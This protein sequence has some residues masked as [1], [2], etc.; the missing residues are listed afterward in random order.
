VGVTQLGVLDKLV[1]SES[2]A[3][4][5]SPA[6]AQPAAPVTQPAT[7]EPAEPA[8]AEEAAA[9]AP[10]PKKTGMERLAAQLEKHGVVVVVVYSPD[11]A[12]DTLVIAAAR[13]GAKAADAGFLALNGAKENEIGELAASLNLRLTPTTLVFADAPQSSQLVKKFVGYVDGET[14]AQAAQDARIG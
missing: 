6:Q 11:S 2:E 4:A 12:V 5:A 9:P 14:V 13:S 3:A 1:G 7:P 8:V 10:K